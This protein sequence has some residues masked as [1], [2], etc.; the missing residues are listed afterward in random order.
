MND[1]NKY[2]QSRTKIEKLFS[3]VDAD[4]IIYGH[5]H[6]KNIC[7]SDKLYINAGSLGCPAKDVNIARY[8]ILEIIDGKVIIEAKELK[9]DSKAVV[10][11]ID[12]YKYPAS[13]EIKK[14]FFGIM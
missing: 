10:N 9:Y 4:I 11:K 2:F 6:M 8:G 5:E 14:F 7:N 1:D 12:E 3:S 13:D